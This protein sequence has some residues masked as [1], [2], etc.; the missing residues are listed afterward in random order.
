MF[1]NR[2][3]PNR[4]TQMCARFRISICEIE[5]FRH[6][7]TK[8]GPYLDRLPYD[9]PCIAKVPL[10]LATTPLNTQRVFPVSG[11]CI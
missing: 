8:Y 10:P 7:I 11:I 6:F 1:C 4:F 5:L 3:M 9:L 2:T